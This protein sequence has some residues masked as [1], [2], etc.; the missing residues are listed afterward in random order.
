MKNGVTLDDDESAVVPDIGSEINPLS[1]KKRS[2]EDH[3]MSLS[4]DEE[5]W[6]NDAV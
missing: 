5:L 3:T 2:T 1:G 4:R 6:K